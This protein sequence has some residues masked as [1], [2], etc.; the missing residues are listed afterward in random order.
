MTHPSAVSRGQQF[1][2]QEP[3]TDKEVKE[4]CAAKGVEGAVVFTKGD[5]NGARTRPTYKVGRSLAPGHP[6][7]APDPCV[8]LSSVRQAGD[9]HGG[10]RMEL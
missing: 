5:V 3:G 4:F 9:W 2:G 10:H 6:T 8:V 1:G 7:Q